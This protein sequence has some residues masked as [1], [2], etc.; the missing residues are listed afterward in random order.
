MSNNFT[1]SDID[2]LLSSVNTENNPLPQW[3]NIVD[4]NSNETSE[5]N[6]TAINNMGFINSAT[7]IES[8][9]SEDVFVNNNIALSATSADNETSDMPVQNGGFLSATSSDINDIFIGQL[10]GNSNLK[11]TASPDDI[12]NLIDMLTS[13]KVNDNFDTVT[14]ITNTEVLETQLRELLAQAKNDQ[15][16]GAKKK[17]S[18]KAAKKSSKKA[19]KSAKKSSK[20]S[21][22]KASKKYKNEEPAVETKEKKKRAPNPALIAFG[23]L[24]KHV[25]EKLGISNG[26][27]AKKVA[28]AA[29]REM[30]EQHP[31]LSAV[32]IAQKAQEHFDKNMDKFR[33]LIE[34]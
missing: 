29:N 24:S 17:S 32:E 16:G 6:N 18:K 4:N 3:L 14:S 13:E 7:S 25:A 27:K 15:Q 12:N 21:S 2:N 5:N 31:N 8:A 19:S 20:K 26:P 23:A 10:G 28:G 33:K 11:V 22:K 9:T 34:E 30:K 1:N